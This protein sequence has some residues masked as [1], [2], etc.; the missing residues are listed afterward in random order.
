MCPY[1]EFY[2]VRIVCAEFA[3]CLTQYHGIDLMGYPP[4]T[5]S[6]TCR[7]YWMSCAGEAVGSELRQHD[8]PAAQAWFHQACSVRGCN[9]TLKTCVFEVINT[10]NAR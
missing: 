2:P 9:A 10:A 7:M 4:C 8:S 1:N 6:N 3:Q 5:A